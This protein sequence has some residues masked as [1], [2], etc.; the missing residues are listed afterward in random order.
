MLRNL[1]LTLTVF[2]V[3]LLSDISAQTEIN[4]RI[5]KNRFKKAAYLSAGGPALFFG[6]NFDMRLRRGS[7]DGL[8]FRVGLGNSFITDSVQGIAVRYLLFTF[9]LGINYLTGSRNGHL[10]MEAGLLP[11]FMNATVKSHNLSINQR[12]LVGGYGMLG[13]RYQPPTSNFMF[14][15]CW[16]PLVISGG[17]NQLFYLELGIGGTF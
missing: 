9:P 10:L 15:F 14:Q 6:A 8:G 17:P 1:K 2:F 4:P 11:A 7:R 3:I 13:Y 5:D 12:S 16:T